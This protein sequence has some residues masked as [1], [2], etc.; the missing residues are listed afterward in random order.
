MPREQHVQ[1]AQAVLS[2]FRFVMQKAYPSLNGR[3]RV[4]Q[5]AQMEVTWPLSVQCEAVGALGGISLDVVTKV[6]I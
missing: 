1:A 6:Q 5:E 4:R 3:A 2:Q